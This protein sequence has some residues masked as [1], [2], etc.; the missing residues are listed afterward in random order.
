MVPSRAA[1]AT[2]S[3][4]VPTYLALNLGEFC[5]FV[6]TGFNCMHMNNVQTHSLICSCVGFD[7]GAAK[8]SGNKAHMAHVCVFGIC[9]T[10]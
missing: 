4:H 8:M 9:P 3:K 5:M 2:L 1:L 6:L 10:L 7:F